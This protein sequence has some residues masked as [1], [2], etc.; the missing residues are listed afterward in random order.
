M[1]AAAEYPWKKARNSSHDYLAP[2]ILRAMNDAGVSG[3]ARIL[4]AGCGGGYIL[5]WLSRNGYREIWGFD[6]SESGIRVAR[7][8][9]PELVGRF[10]VH[11]A[12][13]KRLPDRFPQAGYR[14]VLSVEV[15]EH[16]YSPRAY[17]A[18]IR[19]WLKPGGHLILT[20][21]YHGFL[22][23]LAIALTNSFD[24]H[25]NP[26]E[27][28]GHIRFFSKD[29]LSR[30]LRETGFEPLKF[31]GCGRTAHLWKSLVV[32]AEAQ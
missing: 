17:L 27:E 14:A 26:L 10:E 29:T 11:N 12:Y 31:Y 7:E 6:V 22:K 20:T 24:R 21:P 25:V 32:A 13:E 1:I 28:G 23:N 3:D 4:D 19:S 5:Q 9:F 15:I 18:N 30:I 2:S 8:E 16:L